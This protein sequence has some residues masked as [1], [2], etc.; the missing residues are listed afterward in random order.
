MKSFCIINEIKER[1][2]QKNQSDFYR[3]EE[4]SLS[5]RHLKINGWK[6]FQNFLHS[7]SLFNRGQQDAK[8]TND[9]KCFLIYV[10]E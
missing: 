3:T 1:E 6:Y 5:T 2:C 9:E 4:V 7:F 8:I 10:T